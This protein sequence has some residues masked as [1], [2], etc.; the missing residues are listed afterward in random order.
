MRFFGG[1]GCS[2]AELVSVLVSGSARFGRADSREVTVTFD[3]SGAAEL[4]TDAAEELE[5]LE[6]RVDAL[7][8]AS[9]CWRNLRNA[10]SSL[11]E[12]SD[13]LAVRVVCFVVFFFC[14]RSEAAEGSR[15]TKLEE[16]A[17]ES[18]ELLLTVERTLAPARGGGSCVR[19]VDGASCH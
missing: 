7:E 18:V 10:S 8:V 12:L 1:S 3:C 16:E 14:W 6:G 11:A 9:T 19:D 17:A 15:E 2:S 5:R 13:P 4:A